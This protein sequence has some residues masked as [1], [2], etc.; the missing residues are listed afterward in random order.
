MVSLW[1]VVWVSFKRTF[2]T[3]Y[4]NKP[5]KITSFYKTPLPNNYKNNSPHDGALGRHE[6]GI[7]ILKC[8]GKGC[9]SSGEGRGWAGWLDNLPSTEC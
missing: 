1:V 2:S 9:L 4:Q 3:F 6:Q 8:S 7:G 5:F